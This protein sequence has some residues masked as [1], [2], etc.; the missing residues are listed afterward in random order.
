MRSSVRGNLFDFL[1][2]TRKL[3]IKDWLWIDALAINQDNILE[4]NHQ[5]QQMGDIYRGAKHVLVYP[6]QCSRYLKWAARL[7]EDRYSFTVFRKC[8]KHTAQ[9]SYWTRAWI[10]QEL[11]LAHDCHVVNKGGCIDWK[12]FRVLY[13]EHRWTKRPAWASNV[14]PFCDR[15]FGAVALDRQRSQIAETFDS[16]VRRFIQIGHWQRLSSQY[17]AVSSCGDRRDLVYSLLGLVDDAQGFIVDYRKSCTRL[18]LDT[19][20]HFRVDL[21]RDV[22]GWPK[23]VLEKLMHALQVKIMCYCVRCAESV[24]PGGAVLESQF[25]GLY[26]FSGL[27]MAADNPERSRCSDMCIGCGGSL[28]CWSPGVNHT[29]EAWKDPSI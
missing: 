21:T 22:V 12:M 13:G 11:I 20:Y 28:V 14:R 6:G 9:L 18:F 1:K 16:L 27:I 19:V 8:L 5:V 2:L 17:A 3:K 26:K 29:S 15:Y 4:R 7:G 25:A 24:A 23:V 10:V